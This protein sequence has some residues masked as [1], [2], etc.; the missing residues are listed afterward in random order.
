MKPKII[1]ITGFAGSGKDTLYSYLKS[2]LAEK[3]NK[4]ERVSL[5]DALKQEVDP[6]LIES[7]GISVFSCSRAEKE[8]IRPILIEYARIRRARSKGTYYTKL[9]EPQIQELFSNSITP[10][11]TDIRFCEFEEDEYQWLKKNGG[12]LI[13]VTREGIGPA[14]DEEKVKTT[15][16]IEKADFPINW[17]PLPTMSKVKEFMDENYK[18]K[19]IKFLI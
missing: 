11:I 15:P 3:S 19:L 6:F 10:I 16:V 1:G 5:A 7:F 9:I 13:S 8:E 2:I 17:P 4:S 14:N 12:T 18:S